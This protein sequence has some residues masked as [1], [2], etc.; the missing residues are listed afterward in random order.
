MGCAGGFYPELGRFWHARWV[1][2]QSAGGAVLDSV[3]NLCMRG[4]TVVCTV[5][6]IVGM[7]GEPKV[8]LVVGLTC[9]GCDRAGGWD[10]GQADG[11]KDDWGNGGGMVTE[12]TLVQR[13]R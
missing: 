13:L 5:G 10:C 6:V 9:G 11:R 7:T 1:W 2:A 12:A 3:A 8:K 4:P